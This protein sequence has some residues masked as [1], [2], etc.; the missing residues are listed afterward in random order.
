M[1]PVEKYRLSEVAIQEPEKREGL[2][3]VKA[4]ET[5]LMAR[6]LQHYL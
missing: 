6:I 5:I 1:S 2:E 4:H 3:V